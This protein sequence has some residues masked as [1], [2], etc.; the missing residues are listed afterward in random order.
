M[1]EYKKLDSVFHCLADPTR[2][3]ILARVAHRE[4]SMNEIAQ[5]YKRSMSLAAVSKHVQVLAEA[6]L[7]TKRRAGKQQLVALSPP[8]LRD[9]TKFL[10]TFSAQWE[11]RLDSL[12]KFVK[13][14]K[15]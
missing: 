14:I 1:V 13:S 15:K 5:A 4:L 6:K 8:A 10:E 3:D 2:R 11:A 12:G 9:A 7:V